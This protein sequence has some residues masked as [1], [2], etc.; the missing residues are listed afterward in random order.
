MVGPEL[1]ITERDADGSRALRC[2]RE[3][4]FDCGEEIFMDGV[5]LFISFV[6]LKDIGDTTEEFPERVILVLVAVGFGWRTVGT[7][8]EIP[9]ER[10][11]SLSDFFDIAYTPVVLGNRPRRVKEMNITVETVENSFEKLV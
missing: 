7:A 10:P 9:K 2:W 8:I 3:I 1:S 5:E 6:F 4:R 11:D